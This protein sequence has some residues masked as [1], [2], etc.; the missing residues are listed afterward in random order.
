MVRHREIETEQRD[1]GADQPFSLPQRQAKHRSQRQCRRDSQARV[2]RLT[3]S[4]SPWLSLPRGN[5]C[6]G[7]PNGQAA[8]LSQGCI[9]GSRVRGPMP[10]LWDVVAA[11]GIGFERHE[12]YPEQ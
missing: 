1:D 7:K 4:R 10:L 12:T 8:A 2:A 3:T 11:L 9:I 6:V 5:C